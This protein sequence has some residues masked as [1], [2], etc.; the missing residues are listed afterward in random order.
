MGNGFIW[1]VIK[2]VWNLIVTVMSTFGL[3]L[4]ELHTLEKLIL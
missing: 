2:L 4:T 3:K 1:G